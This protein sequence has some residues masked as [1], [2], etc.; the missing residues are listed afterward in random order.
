MS[1]PRLSVAGGELSGRRFPEP[2]TEGFLGIPYAAAPTGAQRWAPPTSARAWTGVRAADMPAPPCPQPARDFSAWAHGPLPATA[3]DSLQLNLWRPAEPA[4]PS[5]RPILVFLH[6][7]GWALGWGSNPLL[8]GR[9]LARALDAIVIT[10]N[11][12]LGS[13][14]WLWHPALAAA[15]GEPQGN[16]GLLDQ[17]AALRWVAEHATALGGDPARVTLAGESAGAGSVL[18]LVGHPGSAG[19]FQR[20]IAQSPPLHE[21]VVDA[22][23]GVGWTVALCEHLGL[24]TDVAAA[25]PRLRELRADGIVAAQEAL[26]AGP[27]RGTRGGAMPIMD[28]ASLPF[29]PARA[30]GAGASVPLLIGTNA[31]EGTFFFRGGGRRL[32][33]AEPELEAMVARLAHADDPAQLV[34]ATREH[35][36]AQDLPATAN[37]VICA[38]VTET[39]FAGPGRRYAQARAASG[40]EVHRYRI[41]HP[42]AEADLGATHS[43]SVPLLFG[44]W[45]EGG[46]AARLAGS[47]P[48]TAA[49]TAAIDADWARFVHGEPLAWDPVAPE[50]DGPAEV[51]VYGGTAE[52]R[53]IRRVDGSAHPAEVG[54]HGL[55]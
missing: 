37:D 51:A 17:L 47:D 55:Q 23:R 6:G 4:G 38:V 9:H 26:L 24:G 28:S 21:L 3:E 18:H 14:G 20:A 22:D 29:D 25:L 52:S 15:P 19:L 50:A 27:F 39:W 54:T 7:G 49:V 30:P 35:L 42:S 31:N 46:V 44:S 1:A 5:G 16:W 12:R 34:A 41:D 10:L 32:D 33:P 40:G 36:V 13:L 48:A 53:E 11:Y 2:D 43:I 8:E 45:H